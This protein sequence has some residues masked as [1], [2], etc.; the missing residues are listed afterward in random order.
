MSDLPRLQK[1]S[2]A[3]YWVALVLS[4]VLPIIVLVYAGQGVTDPASLLS[5]APALPGG[6]PVTSAQAGLVAGLALV[7]VLPMVAALRGMVRLFGAY[8]DGE[9]LS[10][11]NADRILGIGRNLLMVA[12]FTVLVPTVQ[13]LILS[14][15][16]PQRTLSIGIDGGT[17]G[18]LMAAG[19]LTVI[20]YAMGDAAR[21]K[22][23][24]E[25][26]V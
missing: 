22:A 14:W 20:G 5:R 17:L 15:N 10:E 13:T 8:R 2:A 21:V 9:V 6:T 18:F 19:L 24:N 25:E 12:V 3:L 1:L 16:A 11:A 7:S 4:V 26:F 23:E